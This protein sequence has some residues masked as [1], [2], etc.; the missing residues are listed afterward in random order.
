MLGILNLWNKTPNPRS[1]A[2]LAHSW[3]LEK[4]FCFSFVGTLNEFEI[5]DKCR[6]RA[7]NTG[8][9]NDQQLCAQV[10]TAASLPFAQR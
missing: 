2:F 8:S 1:T 6:Q 7:S 9:Q 10:R 4:S 5:T 3:R